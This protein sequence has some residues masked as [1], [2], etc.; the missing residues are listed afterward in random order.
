MG[1]LVT[2]YA[3]IAMR[4][5]VWTPLW[6]GGWVVGPVL[7]LLGGNAIVRAMRGRDRGG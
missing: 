3:F 5:G 2:V 6:I 4:R 1:A 7:L